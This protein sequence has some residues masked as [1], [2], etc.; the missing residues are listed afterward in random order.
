MHC[1]ISSVVS[2]SRGSKMNWSPHHGRNSPVHLQVRDGFSI[3]GITKHSR[4]T[5]GSPRMFRLLGLIRLRW[6]GTLRRPGPDLEHDTN[7]TRIMM[8]VGSL[9]MSPLLRSIP[10]RWIGSWTRAWLQPGNPIGLI[11]PWMWGGSRPISLARS[12][13]RLGWIGT[14][15]PSERPQAHGIIGIRHR[16]RVGFIPISR[17]RSTPLSL[18]GSRNYRETGRRQH[19]VSKLGSSNFSMTMRGSTM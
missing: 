10:P 1:S 4:R 3:D 14:L 7:G 5:G 2:R 15:T 12:L 16:I 6:T 19:N 13:T 9:P 11:R 18:R 17:S 8:M